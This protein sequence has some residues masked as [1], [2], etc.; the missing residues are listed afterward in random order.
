MDIDTVLSWQVPEFFQKNYNIDLSGSDADN[1]PIVLSPFGEWPLRKMLNQG[2]KKE[3]QRFMEQLFEQ[4]EARMKGKVSRAGVPVSQFVFIADVGKLSMK[5]L[6]KKG[7]IDV[8]LETA[9]SLEA[10]RPES[11]K[12]YYRHYIIIYMF[13]FTFLHVKYAF[14][15]L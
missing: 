15:N 7:A 10:N 3:H 13:P 11:V 6:A 12:G 9:R 1:A 5:N 2:L 14:L 8:L 4:V